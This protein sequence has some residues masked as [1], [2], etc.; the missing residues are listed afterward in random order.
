MIYRETLKINT[1]PH[2]ALTLLDDG[3]NAVVSRSGIRDG[4]VNVFN[5]GSTG[6]ITTIEFE[7]G[8]RSDLPRLLER[9]IPPGGDYQ[10]ELTWHDGNGHSHLQ[11]SVLGP[12]LTV[13]LEDGKLLLGTWQQIVHVEC[14][15]RAR[16]RKVIVTVIGDENSSGRKVHK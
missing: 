4:I 10:H 2:G 6:A 7:P 9:L 1:R 16:S 14:D 12:S 13:P 3:I 5:V 15:V 11:A 8:L